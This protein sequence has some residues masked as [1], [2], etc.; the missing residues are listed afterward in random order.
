MVVFQ[1]SFEFDF[2]MD[3]PFRLSPL[4]GV[5]IYAYGPTRRFFSASNGL[6]L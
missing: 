1:H 3:V 4:C 6:D 2:W 5:D